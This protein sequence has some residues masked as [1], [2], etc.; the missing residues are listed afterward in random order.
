[1]PVRPRRVLVR[2]LVQTEEA[3]IDSRG[4]VGSLNLAPRPPYAPLM[5]WRSRGPQRAPKGVPAGFIIPACR[6]TVSTKP[7]T[8]TGWVHEVKHDGYRLQIHAGKRRVRLY[9]MNGADW[10][11]R[12]ALVIE[13]ARRIK[14]PAVID[15]EVVC[16]DKDGRADFD[17]LQSRC[18]EHEAIAC[19]FD[20]LKL[21]G[22]DLRRL[23]LS[24]RKARMRKLLSRSADG[25]QYLEHAEGDGDAMYE[26]AC[27]LDLEGI[28]SKRLTAPYKSGPCKS[29]IKIRNLKSP[30]YLRIEDGTF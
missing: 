18:F 13:E 7:P 26:A 9:T 21:D 23:P 3:V 15:A 4:S 10:T 11:D 14:V 24:E 17:R 16:T 2:F 20:L 27:R 19:A 6:S 8:G 22:D 12:Y 30:A 25:I 28:L 1:M 29:W 5:L